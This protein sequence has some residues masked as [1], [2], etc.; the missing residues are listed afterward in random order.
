MYFQVSDLKRKHFLDLNNNDNKPIY[1]TYSKGSAWLKYFNLSNSLCAHVT[2]LVT[3]YAF[4]GK[5]QIK[6]FPNKLFACLCSNSPIKTRSYIINSCIQY[7]KSWNPKRESLKNILMFLKF[8]P[9]AFYF[10]KSII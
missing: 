10:Q 8:N 1:P 7:I 4:I 6:F 5:Y 9:R 3:N 2:R